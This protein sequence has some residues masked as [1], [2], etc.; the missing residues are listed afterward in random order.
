M[1]YVALQV[2]LLLPLFAALKHEKEV[3]QATS[4]LKQFGYLPT[5]LLHSQDQEGKMNQFSEALRL[6]QNVTDLPVTGRLDN[7]TLEIMKMP[8]CGLKDSFNLKFL[9]FCVVGIWH[10]KKLSYYIHN[11]DP[12]LG[13]AKTQ[14]AIRA[15]FKYWSDV[16][17]LQF[18]EVT[19][20]DADIELAFHGKDT[21]CSMPFDGPGKTLAHAQGPEYGIVHFDSDELWTDRKQYGANLRI[22]AAHEIGHAL[23][24]GHSRYHSA[25][26]APIYH[27]NYDNFQ[28]HPDDIQGIQ[29][30]YG[31]PDE[32]PETYSPPPDPCT[33]LL[34]AIIL[35]PFHKTFAFSG[36][37]VW[38]ISDSGY[39][40]PVRINYL[41]KELPGHLNAA[42][43]SLRTKKSYFIKGNK[44]WRYT[45]FRLDRDFPKILILPANIDAA[46][47][48]HSNRTLI[49]IKGSEYW[50]WDE[51]GSGEKLRNYP[52]PL[53]DLVTGF[54]SSPDAAFTWINSYVY[55]FKG[56][57]YWRVNPGRFIEKG[58]PFSIRE[59][60]MKCG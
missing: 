18:Y 42:V 47:Y 4:Y 29:A 28:L 25:L 40:T 52:K 39:N 22:V 46:F 58:Y 17:P 41:W 35:G 45:Y 14:Q 27:S 9:K 13:M 54:P 21:F 48:S 10:K 33:A 36:D 15:A 7:A 50:E 23:G 37:Y 3:E 49:F 51:L 11:Y 24:L 30:L 55:V 19:S 44:V 60:W 56:D 5:S 26:M 8:R 53:S 1:H 59:R 2:L 16:T 20:Q 31:K 43:H 12:N 34:D 32:K 57:L 6:F 38:T